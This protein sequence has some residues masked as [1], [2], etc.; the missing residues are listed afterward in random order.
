MTYET[1]IA[2]K[3]AMSRQELHAACALRFAGLHPSIAIVHD[4]SWDGVFHVIGANAML[5]VGHV[6][7]PWYLPV[8]SVC[9]FSVFSTGQEPLLASTDGYDAETTVAF[10]NAHLT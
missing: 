2:T 1:N 8:Q 5:L 10:L 9:R 7:L 3:R 4:A 6:E